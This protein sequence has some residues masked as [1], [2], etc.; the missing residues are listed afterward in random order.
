M[1]TMLG[2]LRQ[3]LEAGDLE[4]RVMALEKRQSEPV[5]PNLRVI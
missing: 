1:A 4:Q 5:K 2:T 3:C